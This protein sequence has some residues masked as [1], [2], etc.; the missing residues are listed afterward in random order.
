M[1]LMP[2][3]Q[4]RTRSELTQQLQQGMAGPPW[5]PEDWE[6]RATWTPSMRRAGAAAA[7]GSASQQPAALVDTPAPGIGTGNDRRSQAAEQTT[8][9]SPAGSPA[10]GSM[11]MEVAGER[12]LAALDVPPG[13]TKQQQEQVKQLL[14]HLTISLAE[15][16]APQRGLKLLQDQPLLSWYQHS[17]RAAVA[18]AAAETGRAPLVL[19]LANGGGGLLALLAAA[20]GAG[21]V[22]AVEKW[23]W[24]CRASKQLLQANQKTHLDLVSRIEIVPGPLSICRFAAD[25]Q[26]QPQPDSTDSATDSDSEADVVLHVT[27]APQQ[28][29]DHQLKQQQQGTGGAAVSSSA[30][31]AAAAPGDGTGGFRLARQADVLIT[32]MFDYR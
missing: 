2:P 7:G 8:Q 29:A 24:G 1:S 11:P 32:D 15:L 23:R 9:G 16:E 19:V 20:E 18:A 6:W 22:V 12:L 26:Q 5:E 17:I 21:H 4:A 25:T 30:T 14:A 13:S 31:A 27:D 3:T 28:S 10:A